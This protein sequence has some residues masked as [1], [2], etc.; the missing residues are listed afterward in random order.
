MIP[1]CADRYNMEEGP[2]SND[3]DK[4]DKDNDNNDNDCNNDGDGGRDSKSTDII[5]KVGDKA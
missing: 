2:S 3:K 5:K 1:V 4:D